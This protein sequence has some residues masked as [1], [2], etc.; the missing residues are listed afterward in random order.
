MKSL[1]KEDLYA[2]IFHSALIAIAVTDKQGNFIAV[3]PA[4]CK[5]L[6][7]TE[8][9]AKT[10]NIKD[11]TLVEE[12]QIINQELN[13][14]A[15]GKVSSLRKEQRYKRKDG[16]MFWASLYSSALFDDKEKVIGILDIFVDIDTQVI[17][18][19]VHGELFQSLETLNKEL[20]N[21]NIGLK[22][23]AKYDSLTG[24]YNRWVMEEMLNKEIN[25]SLET[26]RGF[27]VGIADIDDFKKVNDAYGHDCGDFVLVKLTQSFLQKIR[28]TDS[29]CRWGGEEFLFLFPETIEQGAMIVVERIRKSIEELNIDYRGNLIKV[30]ITIGVSFYNGQDNL[31]GKELVNRADKALYK[32]KSEGKNKVVFS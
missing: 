10:L 3:N 27:A 16:T 30:T 32:G 31:D 15:I 18:E 22:R 14:I 17:S 25:R 12:Q 13:K 6:G 23:Q 1:L 20:S 9:E 29:V 28:V 26:K 4:W 24:L 5:S 19:K 11:I 7:W 21:A 2:K 8:T